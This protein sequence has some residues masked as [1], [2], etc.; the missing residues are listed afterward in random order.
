MRAFLSRQMA[1]CDSSRPWPVLGGEKLSDVNVL[2]QMWRFELTRSEE[3]VSRGM[4][5]RGGQ[6]LPHICY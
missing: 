5:R 1:G 6:N 3:R 4:S 2:G